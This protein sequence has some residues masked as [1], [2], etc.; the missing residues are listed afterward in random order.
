MLLG[1]IGDDFTGSS[2]LGNTLTRRGMRCVQYVGVPEGPATADVEA[3]IVALKSRSVPVAEAVRQSL[4]ALDWLRAQGCRQFLFK[5]CST[6]DST[7]EGNIGPV[8]EALANALGARR[9]LVCPAFPATGR[10]V[11]QGHLFVGDRLLSESGMEAHPLTPMT[12][13]DLRRWLSRQVG[14]T[15]GHVPF[16][17]VAAGADA[18]RAR[19]RTEDAAGHR[20]LVADAIR[21]ADLEVL[22]RATAGLPLVTGGSGIALG[23]PGVFRDAGLLADTAGA[24]SGQSG[25]AAILSGSCSRATRAQVARHAETDP[26]REV[27]ADDVMAGRISPA[28][29]AEWA[30]TQEGVPLIYTSADPDAVR[31]A[32]DRH[33]RAAVAGAIEAL[34]AETAR[35]LVAAGVTR[36]VT[37]GGE[38]SGA[39]VEGLSLDRLEIGPEIDPGVPMMRAGA[40]LV[41]ALKSGNF[42]S[43]DFFAKAVRMMEAA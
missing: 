19:M 35:A 24:W 33:G 34:F 42:G 23:L 14:G 25:P 27:H 43:P 7:P 3:G 10:S 8:A 21:D 28:E 22:G 6:F 40:D 15:V 17:D 37:A 39:V 20:L 12:D 36:L 2:D 13:P 18:V 1:C 26:A 41:L 30:R 9:V 38:T 16:A 32:Q 4:A 31:A 29:L 11:Y 5:Y